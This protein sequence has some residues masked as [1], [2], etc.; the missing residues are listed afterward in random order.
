MKQL[1]LDN[2]WGPVCTTWRVTIPPFDTVSLHSNMS[3]RGHCMWVHMQTG[4]T[5]GVQLPTS[6]V[7]TVTYGELYLGS[8]WVPIYLWNVSTH[9]V[10]IPAKAVVGQV[11]PDNQ[12]L[13]VVLLEGT[14]GAIL[15]KDG[16]WRPWTSKLRGMAWGWA[17]KGQGVAAE[18]RTPVYP[19]H[20][21]LGRT[22]LIKHQT[23]VI[24]WMPFKEHYWHIPAHMYDDV[25]AHLQEMLDIGA[26]WKLH[27]LWVSAAFLVWKKDGSL[28]FCI[29][30]RKLNNQTIKD[31][32]LL[33]H[34][35]KTLDSLQASQWFF[36]LNLKL[37]YWQVK[38]D[39][40][41]KLLTAFTVGPLVFYEHKRMP[42]RLI[43]VLATFQRLMETYLGDLNLHWRIIYL[44]DIVILSKDLASHLE[45]LE[46]VLELEE[47]GL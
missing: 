39:E 29:D 31:A 21:D 30:P 47:A 32:Y 44:D 42:F 25:K 26:I 8:S 5:T 17:W 3:V 36:S 19:Q 2:V 22:T 33:F 12:V 6:V 38:M 40:E 13:P 28:R 23:E 14:L 34:I 18:M 41:S 15:K 10:E 27:I 46:A 9:P 43:N 20:L 37:G 11:M 7:P 35:D 45:R 16:S 24:D 4:P 1:C